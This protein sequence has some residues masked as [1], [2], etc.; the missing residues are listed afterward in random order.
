M[1]GIELSRGH[2]RAAARQ[3][4]RR[5]A[6]PVTIGDMATTTVAG[7]FSLVYLV[8]NTIVNLTSQDAQVGLLRKRGRAP[9]ARAA[10]S[11]SR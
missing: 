11:S 9:R 5:D 6:I 3:A 1:T 4:R 7:T 2:G 10:A 8:F